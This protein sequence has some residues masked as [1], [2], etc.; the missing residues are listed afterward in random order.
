MSRKGRNHLRCVY[1]AVKCVFVSVCLSARVCL[2]ERDRQ[3]M[4]SRCVRETDVL[5]A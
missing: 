1:S 3:V 4:T 2:R 5:F